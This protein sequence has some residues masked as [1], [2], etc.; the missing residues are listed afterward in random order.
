MSLLCL[1]VWVCFGLIWLC[2]SSAQRSLFLMLL[3]GLV[4]ALLDSII[5]LLLGLSTISIPLPP[6]VLG[7]EGFEGGGLDDCGF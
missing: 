4:F 7:G 6:F 5:V 2:M 3:L 1:S